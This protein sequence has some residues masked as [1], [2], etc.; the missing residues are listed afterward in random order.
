[1]SDTLP[2]FLS[3]TEAA[4]TTFKASSLPRTNY[5][6]TFSPGVLVGSFHVVRR[7]VCKKTLLSP[8]I[9]TLS[10]VRWNATDSFERA[11][12][13]MTETCEV[14]VVDLVLATA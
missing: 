11:Y 9:F 2:A 12:C 8:R 6:L 1:M 4:K 14:P 10:F 13:E 5:H 7:T 3:G